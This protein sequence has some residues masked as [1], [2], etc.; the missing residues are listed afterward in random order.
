MCSEDCGWTVAFCSRVGETSVWWTNFGL[1]FLFGG[2]A[3]VKLVTVPV[4]LVLDYNFC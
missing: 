4:G 3:L 2:L 1:Q